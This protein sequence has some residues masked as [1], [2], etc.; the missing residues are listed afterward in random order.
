MDAPIVTL[1][2]HSTNPQAYHDL[3]ARKGFIWLGPVVRTTI[4]KT[5]WQ[6]PE[7]H[8][9]ETTYQSLNFVKGGCR[10]CSYAKLGETTRHLP[11]EYSELAKSKG[12]LWLGPEV[13]RSD[14][15]TWWECGK[16]HRWQTSY[17]SIHAGNGCN[18][19]RKVQTED[20][21]A[22]AKQFGLVW[23][24]PVVKTA[25]AL[26]EWQCQKGHRFWSYYSNIR[27]GHG[28]PDCWRVQPE[29]YHELANQRG[30][31]WVGEMPERTTLPT[32]WQCAHG[33]RWSTSYSNLQNGSGCYECLDF[34]NGTM[35]SKQQRA[36]HGIVGGVLNYKVGRFAIDVA[37]FMPEAKIACE[38]DCY[39]WHSTTAER[40]R[41]KAQ[42]LI[43]RGWKVFS[44]KS[45]NSLPSAEQ[46]H[47][48]IAALLA[49]QDYYEIVLDDWG[50]GN[51]RR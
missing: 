17:S 46:I 19:C 36:L 20:Y 43:D 51:T 7:G 49:G 38:Y 33:H 42:L 45:K 18:Q 5:W 6:C 29:A 35:V 8:K 32:E 12:F 9:I 22:A 26:T 4:T 11:G 41:K 30:F 13:K 25:S 27:M 21:H 48:A 47:A 39:Y 10:I 34:V 15:Y 23:L 24:G 37:V 50:T 1:H 28:C 14:A 40:D 2:G 16:G 44:I 31:L 3:A